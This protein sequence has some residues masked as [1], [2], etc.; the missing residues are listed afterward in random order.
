[1]SQKERRTENLLRAVRSTFKEAV[2][3]TTS[4]Q[5]GDVN[6]VALFATRRGGSTWL[7]HVIAAAPGFRSLDQPFSV[8]TAN[9]TPGHYRRVPKYAY[10]EIV[11]SAPEE[12]RELRGYV[13]ALVAGDIPVNAPF[14][15]WRNDFRFKTDRQV[16]KI[17]GAKS[18]IG[19]MD[20]E[21]DLDIV[22]LT[23]HPITQAMSWIRNGWTLTTRAYLD[24]AR[25][26]EAH[27]TPQLEGRC[28]DIVERG[29]ALER[30]VL[31]WGLENLIPLRTLAHRP[32]WIS[33]SYEATVIRPRETIEQLAARLSLGSSVH[34]FDAGA[35]TSNARRR[36]DGP[37][38]RA[39]GSRRP[40]RTPQGHEN[41]RANG[42]RPLPARRDRART[43]TT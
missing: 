9:L 17:V 34:L 20:D 18:L 12:L 25:F 40:R 28:H 22:L 42:H 29:S 39:A 8:M 27:L 31:N 5:P 19:W 38:T 11:C 6:D 2:W 1:M 10:G 35:T 15:F 14:R 30:S 7:M 3:L 4:H 43:E 33:V 41:P 36:R 32:S 21:F 26:V 13:A 16:L 23:R 37:A 24:N